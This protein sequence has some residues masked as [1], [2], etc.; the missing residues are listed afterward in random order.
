M[1]CKKK[2]RKIIYEH[3]NTITVSSYVSRNNMLSM[4][5]TTLYGKP[6][7]WTPLFYCNTPWQ[8]IE[9]DTYIKCL[10][11]RTYI[12]GHVLSTSV[13]TD[14]TQ[15]TKVHCYIDVEDVSIRNPI[16]H[17]QS[18]ILIHKCARAC[19]DVRN[20]TFVDIFV[21]ESKFCIQEGQHFERCICPSTQDI[22]WGNHQNHPSYLMT[23]IPLLI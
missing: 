9:I 4:K 3:C 7:F 12:Y 1:D 16:I 22:F 5:K 20:I 17:I 19:T 11:G 10:S 6:N 13:A 14:L 8:I 18:I 21:H 15:T 23:T 2:R